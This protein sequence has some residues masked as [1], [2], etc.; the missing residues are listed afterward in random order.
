MKIN[1]TNSP[2]NEEQAEQLNELL[3]TLSPEQKMWL[4]GYILA[5]EQVSNNEKESTSTLNSSDS[6]QSNQQTEALLAEK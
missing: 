1:I 5:S 6:L 4:S 2:F 3:Q